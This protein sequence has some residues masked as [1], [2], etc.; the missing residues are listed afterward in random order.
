M[1]LTLRPYQ[2][3]D[4][5]RVR[6]AFGEYR[7]V[8]LTQPTGSGKGT[9]SSYIVRS[10]VAKGSKC[11][12]LVNRRALVND[13]SERLKRLDVEHGVIMGSEKYRRKAW[14]P[15]QAAS[16]DT[17]HRRPQMPEAQLVIIDECRFATSP[18]WQS[19]IDKYPDANILGLDATPIASNGRGLGDVFE[20]LVQGPQ[21]QELI[22]GGFLVPSRLFQLPQPDISGVKTNKGGDFNENALAS[23]VDKQMI[24]GDVVKNWAKHARD[25][26]TVVFAVNKAHAAHLA[27]Q[28]RCEGVECAYVDCDTDDSVGGEREKI[29]RDLDTGSLR[30]V[31][32]V[33]TIG[34]GWDH[35]IVSCVVGA[36][37]TNSL[38]LWLQQVGRAS[39]PY[40]NKDHMIV[41]DNGGNSERLDA[42]YED[43]RHWSLESGVVKDDD[44]T[45]AVK[46]TTC[47]QCL[48]CYRAG[49]P[50]CPYCGFERPKPELNVQTV[51]ADLQE[52]K[53]ERKAMSAE[54]WKAHLDTEAKQKEQYFELCRV[55][56]QRGYKDGWPG[57]KY[58]TMTGGWPKGGWKKQAQEAGFLPPPELKNG[59]LFEA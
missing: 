48:R 2:E 16:I 42:L 30:V 6:E 38:A 25:H 17:L 28:Y 47:K 11:I 18:I 36:R 7:T 44:D 23:A 21:V 52:R 59:R 26:K 51:E 53:R 50:K 9:L 4:L 22:N 37:P 55:A 19:V 20:Y 24:I 34:Y 13:M 12:F 49:R 54:E 27:E 46:V 58:K 56:K 14:L 57:M 43:D 31:C 39:R 32:S 33:G 10:A 1:A 41:L 29:W 3:R 40:P 8:L 5:A 45:E 35:P 15:V